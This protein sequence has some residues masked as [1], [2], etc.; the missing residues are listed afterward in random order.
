MSYRELSAWVMGLALLVG[1]MFYF[2]LIVSVSLQIGEVVPPI[3]P[4]IVFFTLILLTVTI[5]GH[6]CAVIYVRKDA[7]APRDER[8]RRIAARASVTSGY[9]F[10]LGV[11]LS[12]ASYLYYFDGNLLFYGVLAWLTISQLV[13]YALRI[14]LYRSNV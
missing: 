4:S 11:L 10:A 8:D 7:L 6:I 3:M 2:G 5:V 13:E 1:M 12:L 9:V 14:F